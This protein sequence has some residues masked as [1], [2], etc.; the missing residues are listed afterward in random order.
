MKP[1]KMWRELKRLLMTPSGLFEII[2]CKSQTNRNKNT[3]SAN[4]N[5][6]QQKSALNRTTRITA[7]N[8]NTQPTNNNHDQQNKHSF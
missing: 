6:G 7:H 8:K 1:S 4:R 5:Q 3:L 2:G